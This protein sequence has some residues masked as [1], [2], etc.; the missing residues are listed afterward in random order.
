MWLFIN[1]TVTVF[2][3][4]DH[5]NFHKWHGTNYWMC[6]LQR[7]PP[8]PPPPSPP[9]HSIHAECRWTTHGVMSPA[10][11]TQNLSK[12][13]NLDLESFAEVALHTF[14]WQIKD[15]TLAPIN[16]S[17]ADDVMQVC[18]CVYLSVCLFVW[19]FIWEES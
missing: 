9:A 8:P 6:R 2:T 10:A 18:L 14:S 3:K 7:C 5:I 19:V 11:W 1:Y 15:E 4:I 16:C 13:Q 17:A 12:Y